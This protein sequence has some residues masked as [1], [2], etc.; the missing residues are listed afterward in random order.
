MLSFLQTAQQFLKLEKVEIGG[1]RGK[2]LSSRIN[3][4]HE[5]FKGTSTNDVRNEWGRVAKM[6]PN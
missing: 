4:V 6:Q 1:I 3:H 2:A 5:E